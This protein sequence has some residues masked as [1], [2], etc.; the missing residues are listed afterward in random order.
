[1]CIAPASGDSV[2]NGNPPSS[3]DGIKNGNETDIDCGSSGA[4]A[5]TNAPQCAIGK[6][7]GVDNDC[8]GAHVCNYTHKCVEAPSCRVQH[9][10]DTC[11]AGE[12]GH[13]E[14]HE[15]CCA[16]LPLPGNSVRVDKYEITA[17]R[18]REFLNAVNND[19]RGWWD[20]HPGNPAAGQIRS[21]DVKYLPQGL[22]T[23]LVPEFEGTNGGNANGDTFG[24]YNHVG[25]HVFYG[26]AP[27]SQGCYIGSVEKQQYGHPT[28]WFDPQTR[29]DQ[30]GGAPR[31]YEQNDLDEK[32]LNCVTQI[33]LAAFCAWDGGRLPT[34]TELSGGANSAWGPGGM[35]WGGGPLSF[36]DTISPNSPGR[37]PYGTENNHK[38]ELIWGGGVWAPEKTVKDAYLVDAYLVP[39]IN[40]DLSTNF[41]APRY[42]TTNWNADYPAT[43]QFRYAWPQVQGW[44][45]TDEAY[46]IAAPGRM[47]NDKHATGPG[48]LDGWFDLAGNLMEMTGNVVDSDDAAHGNLPRVQWVGGSFEGH[49]PGRIDEPVDPQFA[50]KFNILVKYGKTGGRCAR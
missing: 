20:A 15:S 23:P 25:E 47:I 41:D 5:P 49:L 26:D 30:F 11:G 46:A 8:T 19:V 33:L 27:S 40:G 42:N 43:P 16:S 29:A 31:V 12:T 36:L 13:G 37:E 44:E 10:G 45:Q 39:M 14:N 38:Q 21:Q 24:V 3:S 6:K 50:D 34:S 28:F 48:A 17:G 9:G 1:V 7:C 4:G 18:V 2:Q 32:S 22:S 35:P